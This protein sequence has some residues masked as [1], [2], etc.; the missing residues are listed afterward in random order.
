MRKEKSE[1]M[2]EVNSSSSANMMQ[3]ISFTVKSTG[4]EGAPEILVRFWQ[5]Q[6]VLPN[7]KTR[8]DLS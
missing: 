3:T 5:I 6:K 7:L 2:L 4:A 1:R 8:T